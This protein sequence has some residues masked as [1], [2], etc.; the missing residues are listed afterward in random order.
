MSEKRNRPTNLTHRSPN[1]DLAPSSSNLGKKKGKRRGDYGVTIKALYVVAIVLAVATLAI[2]GIKTWQDLS[3][4]RNANALL[5]AY[6]EMETPGP[7][8]TATA[9]PETPPTPAP[10]ET[11]GPD[12]DV[13]AN[14][15]RV[16]DGSDQNVDETADYVQPDAPEVSE[17]EKIIQKII[18]SVGEDGVIG[19]LEIPS[20]EQEYPIIGKWSYKLLKISLCRYQGPN[21]N[22]PG[23]LV[24]I[25]HNY[26]SG[27]HFGNLK[28][29]E[30]GDE[31]FL[32]GID[33][34]RIRY[35]VY[36]IKGVAPDAFSELEP[37]KGE[38]G[39]TLMTCKDNG[40]NRLI[41]RCVQKEAPVSASANTTT[42]TNNE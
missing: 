24:L 20:T 5:T 31:L 17:A 3:A 28:K 37:Y 6:K 22:Q 7:T 33:G 40:N 18:A 25:G 1:S 13:V 42:G 12:L 39:L 14:S 9:T 29:L 38:C 32:T 34:K 30:V 41:V 35:E 21:A 10:T 23:N 16:D 19:T 15:H 26:K 27:A 4:E 36:Q 8:A 11:P 2:V